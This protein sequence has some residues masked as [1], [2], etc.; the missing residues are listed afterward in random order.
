[1]KPESRFNLL[2]GLCV[3]NIAI[4]VAVKGIK[5]RPL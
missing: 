3:A 5:S 4:G 2:I 1:M